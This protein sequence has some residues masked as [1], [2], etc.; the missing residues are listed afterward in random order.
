[1]DSNDENKIKLTLKQSI[2][3]KDEDLSLIDQLPIFS[4]ISLA[5]ALLKE[6][7]SIKGRFDDN[8]N[9]MIEKIQ[10]KCYTYYKNLIISQEIYDNCIL[11]DDENRWTYILKNNSKKVI[12]SMIYLPVY[13]F[14]FLLRN[15][16]KIMIRLI[17]RC[18]TKYMDAMS[19]FIAHF[20]YE[21]TINNKNSFIQ[22]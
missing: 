7:I 14:L 13:N 2:S 1:M 11:K 20:C 15:N 21:N 19:Y 10:S 3:F 17:N 16:N 22:E 6:M 12:D 5:Q 9:K 4:K 8:K 18:H